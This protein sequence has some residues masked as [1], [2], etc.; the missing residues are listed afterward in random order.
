MC[1]KCDTEQNYTLQLDVGEAVDWGA[2]TVFS[3][4]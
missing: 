1:Q 3:P 2:G 4:L